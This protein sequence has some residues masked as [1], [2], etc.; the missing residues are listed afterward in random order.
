MTSLDDRSSVQPVIRGLWTDEALPIMQQLSIA[1]FVA[2]GHPYQLYGYE[3]PSGLPSGATFARADSIVLERSYRE[4]CEFGQQ[5]SFRRLFQSRVLLEYGGWWAEPDVIC[6]RPFH[7]PEPYVFGRE[8]QLSWEPVSEAV[9]KAP[10]GSEVIRAWNR[11]CEHPARAP[12]MRSS[13]RNRGLE[14]LIPQHGFE[15]RVRPAIAFSA[16]PYFIRDTVLMPGFEFRFQL[17][18]FAIRLWYDSWLRDELSVDA[19]YAPGSL[20]EQLKSVYLRKQTLQPRC[21]AFELLETNHDRGLDSLGKY[22]AFF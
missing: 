2:K 18:T 17:R 12:S 1:S 5:S 16:L 9:M 14:P 22:P 10:P 6:L 15:H 21:G 4:L 8:H 7:S 13:E 19:D 20:Y 3:V 11:E